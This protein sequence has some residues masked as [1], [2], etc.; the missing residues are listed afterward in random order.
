MEWRFSRLPQVVYAYADDKLHR[1]PTGPAVHS[2]TEPVDSPLSNQ[3]RQSIAAEPE[4]SATAKECPPP[5]QESRSE[6]LCRILFSILKGS[7]SKT[8]FPILGTYFGAR[9]QH[10]W[11]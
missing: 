1:V 2:E 7:N 10:L 5:A 6:L 9:S 4:P 11:F 8:K 3:S